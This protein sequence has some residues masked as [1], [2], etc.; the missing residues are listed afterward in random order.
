MTSMAS[1]F[2]ILGFKLACTSF[3]DL[4]WSCL[5]LHLSVWRGAVYKGGDEVVRLKCKGD[6][7]VVRCLILRLKGGDK[8]VMEV[9][10]KVVSHGGSC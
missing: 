5:E 2:L 6:K 4:P 3:L 9:L 1:S 10:R 8:V 7:E